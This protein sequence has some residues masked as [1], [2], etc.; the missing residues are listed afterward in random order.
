VRVEAS[1][2][3]DPNVL[4]VLLTAVAAVGASIFL[5]LGPPH[6]P[7]DS[8]GWSAGAQ[9]LSSLRGWLSVPAVP[10]VATGLMLLWLAWLV[11]AAVLGLRLLVAVALGSGDVG[12][13]HTWPSL[14]GALLRRVLGAVALLAV[15]GIP[16]VSLPLVH[17]TAPSWLSPSNDLLARLMIAVA[18]I[19]LAWSIGLVLVRL[20][21]LAASATNSARR[22]PAATPCGSEQ[23]ERWTL[24]MLVVGLAATFWALRA[25]V[26]PPHAPRLPDTTPGW[27][28]I[29]VQ[30]Q[31]AAPS[32]GPL[33]D[34]LGLVAWCIWLY[35]ASTLAFRVL[36]A[37]AMILTRGASWARALVAISD[38]ITL[39][40][41]RRG[42]TMAFAISMVA[43]T[44][45]PV[46]AAP[47]HQAVMQVDET[48]GDGTMVGSD[49]GSTTIEPDQESVVDGTGDAGDRTLDSAPVAEGPRL[50]V[51]QPG[52]SPW[53]I[54]RDEWDGNGADYPEL[55]AANYGR[56][57]PDGRILRQASL[58]PGDVLILPDLPSATGQ[59]DSA[60]TVQPPQGQVTYVVQDGDTLWG[61]AGKI[62]GDPTRWPEI[63]ELNRGAVAPDGHVFRNPSLIWRNLELEVDVDQ[64]VESAP[65]AGATPPEASIEPMPSATPSPP[66]E[67]PTAAPT[68]RITPAT[69]VASV[70][71]P[72]ATSDVPP[73]SLA[74]APEVVATPEAAPTVGS[75]E[76]QPAV[77]P[78]LDLSP[79]AFEVGEG[80]AAVALIAAGLY[81]VRRPRGQRPSESDVLLRAGFAEPAGNEDGY[82]LAAELLAEQV[83]AF[84]GEHGCTDVRVMG[85]YAG[86]T[87][88]TLLLDAPTTAAARLEELA[89]SFGPDRRAVR[90]TGPDRWVTGHQHESHYQW[91]QAWSDVRARAVAT[92]PG[93]RRVQL[94]GLG[95]AG[96]RRILYVNWL[97][98]GNLLV[99]GDAPSGLAEPLTALIVD[100]IRRQPPTSCQLVTIARPGR[101]PDAIL[102]LPHQNRAPIDPAD[103]ASVAEVFAAARREVACRLDNS[104]R[105]VVIDETELIIAIDEWS[106]LPEDI[107]ETIDF[108]ARHGPSVGVRLV[109][110][111]TSVDDD[112]IGAWAGLFRTRLVLLVPDAAASIRLLDEARAEDLDR[113]GEAWPYLAGRIL[114]RVRCFRISPDHLDR[115]LMEM[116]DRLHS[117]A[118]YHTESASPI[119]G[120]PQSE[121]STNGSPASVESA[122]HEEDEADAA[123]RESSRQLP[124]IRAVLL[125]ERSSSQLHLQVQVLGSHVTR[126]GEGEEIRPEGKALGWQ[127]FELAASYPPGD[128]TLPLVAQLVWPEFDL[129][130]QQA[131]QRIHN[132]L[133][134]LR[135]VWQPYLG[136]EHAR[137]V[138][139]TRR[140]ALDLNADLVSVD[141]HQFLRAL[142]DAAR[143]RAESDRAERA[144]GADGVQLHRVAEIQ[145]L[146]RA[147]TLY[148]GPVLAGREV[149]YPWVTAIQDRY[150][151]LERS[152]TDRLAGLLLADCR[153]QEAAVLYGD[154]MRD[155]GPLDTERQGGDERGY[156]ERCA[157]ALFEC[158]R[159]LDDLGALVRTR[160]E[161][162][163]IL[164]DQDRD[165]ESLPD[166][167][168]RLETA[169]VDRFGAIYREL[170]AS[171]DRPR[172]G[173]G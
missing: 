167:A 31:S 60:G 153:A 23:G 68:P 91:E 159:Q 96:D 22:R 92:M 137:Q 46:G 112:R 13:A 89:E 111:T 98:A 7:I 69:P 3:G 158:C 101:L 119:G 36:V 42:V 30:F 120:D 38:V 53:Q 157:R 168:L 128:A 102:R 143:A 116:T 124:L 85:A 141:L 65:P 94:V 48:P 12:Y 115:L 104:G 134:D 100:L 73:V 26:G 55:M 161:L 28:E 125:P 34:L 43:R 33:V 97:E 59:Q 109:A 20:L 58:R 149:D 147:R 107:D 4:L 83:L 136:Q 140:K 15:V 71:T 95:L 80:A 93:A 126:V 35:L 32:W 84:L 122:G 130:D 24:F 62:L 79:G 19:W 74:P 108:V 99:A 173:A 52:N 110:A 27:P 106:E 114:P 148:T 113:V 67:E 25:V 8:L 72:V 1:P 166:E 49:G 142:D 66:M 61:I 127:L 78:R 16:G 37:A 90:L 88:A 64:R 150:R 154:L 18:W 146:M 39:P 44:P 132:H 162:L 21:V 131:A 57:M 121:A 172:E 40:A 81:L 145:A 6:L 135:Q 2:G 170:S 5:G 144:G 45:S 165:G 17:L 152:A 171:A 105:S 77:S 56:R 117:S 133:H 11:V 14:T 155:P 118:D 54:A 160:D 86:R 70:P 76:P 164:E 156:R 138:L 151:R 75:D 41:V 123:A 50:Y 103:V 139:R 87:G 169:T 47:V 163:A 82:A 129:T 63:W 29:V 10:S 51:V 9:V